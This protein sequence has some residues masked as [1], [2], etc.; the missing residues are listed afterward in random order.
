MKFEQNPNIIQSL[1]NAR[2]V[3]LNQLKSQVYT[4]RSWFTIYDAQLVWLHVIEIG[5][6]VLSVD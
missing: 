2:W 3:F 5:I 6:K 4:F 1:I